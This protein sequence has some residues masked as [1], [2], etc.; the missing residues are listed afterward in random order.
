[1][2]LRRSVE[3]EPL[4]NG[5]YAWQ[6]NFSP[7]CSSLA[8]ANS[9]IKVLESYL[10]NPEVH[11]KAAAS[12]ALRGGPFVDI[13]VERADAVGR[14]VAAFRTKTQAQ[15]ALA[16]G[17]RAA[18]DQLAEQAE[19]FTF[20]GKDIVPAALRPYVELAYD[21]ENRPTLR[22]REELLYRSPYFDATQQR[23]DMFRRSGD[24]RP[25]ILSTPRLEGPDRLSLHVPMTDE[26]LTSLFAARWRPID[27]AGLLAELDVPHEAWRGLFTEQPPVRRRPAPNGDVNV[28]YFGH[29]CLLVEA[30]GCSLI[31]DPFICGDDGTDR[32]YGWADVPPRIDLCL[33]THAHQDHV[34]PETLMQLRHV[35]RTVVVPRNSP[36]ALQD[37]SL[38]L[39]LRR[40][41]F[42]D[43]VTIGSF[44]ELDLDD[45]VR[46]TAFP[47]FGE[48][49][50]LDI[51]SKLTYR[52]E[53]RGTRLYISADSRPT[54]DEV[55]GTL[56]EHVGEVDAVFL[57]M[58]SEGAPL[59]WLYGPLLSSHISRR[60]SESR[61][62]AALDA[63]E[64]YA[65]ASALGAKSA[66]VYAMGREPWLQHIMATNYTDESPQ[67][68]EMAKFIARC[69]ESGIAADDLIWR[70]SMTF[71]PDGRAVVL[72]DGPM[73]T[74]RGE[75]P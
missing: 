55:L 32:R 30:G 49:A 60:M 18:F 75:G 67:L 20:H 29:A 66:F 25:F 57:G 65:L 40:L 3:I 27:V 21:T 47:F 38:E 64:A 28:T 70:R 12:P 14:F 44:D 59:T 6:H 4:V 22:L 43:V 51:A 13:P 48:H 17:I 5:F 41:G 15:Q 1:M 7:A 68:A 39:Y 72:D 26:R 23:V 73:S 34:V 37:P 50:D 71:S 31:V 9:Q 52:V 8:V 46:V 54:G 58:E 53:A 61:R 11:A 74:T 62:L 19:G 24:R 56:K 36:G 33:I 35:V 42:S 16:A 45:G 2:Y 63:D 10:D 69:R